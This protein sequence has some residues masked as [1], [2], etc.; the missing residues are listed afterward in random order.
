MDG[1]WCLEPCDGSEASRH[2]YLN[3]TNVLVTRFHAASGVVEVEDFMTLGT[4]G[5]HVVRAVRCLRGRIDM[6]SHIDVR[7]NYGRSDVGIT[8]GTEISTIGYEIDGERTELCASGTVDWS[9]S[10]GTLDCSFETRN[11]RFE[12]DRRAEDRPSSAER[13]AGGLLNIVVHRNQGLVERFEDVGDE[14]CNQHGAG[15]LRG[16]GGALVTPAPD[17]TLRERY[18]HDIWYPVSLCA[19]RGNSAADTRHRR[20]G[21]VVDDE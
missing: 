18:V 13:R 3:A 7:P 20:R 2:V 15:P 10:E 14:R 19:M 16:E 6:A 5:Q 1:S 21:N 11:F 12:P 4:S 17:K 9:H 8:E